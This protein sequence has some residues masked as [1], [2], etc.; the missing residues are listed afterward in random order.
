MSKLNQ[1]QQELRSIDQASFQKL[2]DLYLSQQPRYENL[3]PIGSV[4]GADKVR[5]GIPDSIIHLPEGGFAMVSYTTQ[6]ERLFKKLSD[7][8]ED[9][10]SEA[11][12]HVRAEDVKEVILVHNGAIGQ[13]EEMDLMERGRQREA[14]VR[15]IGLETLANNIYLKYK[16]LAKEF[17]GIEIDTGQILKPDDFV[18]LYNK[19]AF[20]TPLDT[21][22]HFREKELAATVDSLRLSSLVLITGSAG[23]G[24]SRLMLEAASRF[25]REDQQSF[26]VQCIFR[27][28][29]DLFEDLMSY[30]S[31][32]GRY[33]ILVDDANR[34]TNNFDYI[35]QLLH[36]QTDDREIKIMATVRDYARER[37]VER[38]AKYG[39]ISE[40]ELK[41]LEDE[42]ILTLVSDECGIA[43]Q[44]YLR[45]I[46]QL[47]QGNPRLAMMAAKVAVETNTFESILNVT[48]LYEEYF[49]SM[50]EDLAEL[51]ERDAIKVAGIV[52]FYR[53]VDYSNPGQMEDIKRIFG[54]EPSRFWEIVNQLHDLE[55]LD[56]HEGEVA[57]LP[58]QI[59][60][61]YLFYLAVFDLKLISFAMLLH[62]FFPRYRDHF[63]DALNPVINA[64]GARVEEQL[65]PPIQKKWEELQVSGDESALEMLIL[66]F[67]FVDPTR[68]LL[69]IR[70][71]IRA[72]RQEQVDIEALD[73]TKMEE[74]RNQAMPLIALLGHFHQPHFKTALDLLFEAFERAPQSFMSTVLGILI[75]DFGYEPY[76]TSHNL[77]YLT[78]VVDQLWLRSDNGRSLLF[79]KLFL[80]VAGYCLRTEYQFTEAKGRM[81]ISINTLK[82]RADPELCELRRLLLRR[83]LSFFSAEALRPDVLRLL[84]RYCHSG[85]EVSGSEIVQSDSEEILPFVMESLD[86]DNYTHV[87]IVQSY[88]GFLARE[89]VAYDF[90]ICDRFTNAAS[91][92]SDILLIDRHIRT[93]MSWQEAESWQDEKIRDW[94]KRNRP[95]D[96]EHFF[97]QSLTIA[98]EAHK[99]EPWRFRHSMEK[100]F[101][102][103]LETG[104]EVFVSVMALYLDMGNPF[105]IVDLRLVKKLINVVGLGEAYDFIN[106]RRFE[107]KTQWIFQCLLSIPADQ[108]R[109]EHL[110]Q[111]YE[112]YGS[113]PAGEILLTFESLEPFLEFDRHF[114]LRVVELLLARLDR[115]ENQEAMFRLDLMFPLRGLT[116]EKVRLYFGGNF[117]VIKQ[118]YLAGDEV[119][120][121]ADYDGQVFSLILDLD[122]SFLR[123]YMD[124]LIEKALKKNER[125]LSR[126]D[127]KREYDFLWRRDD[128]F[129]RIF[130]LVDQFFEWQQSHGIYLNDFP[131]HI[132][133]VRLNGENPDAVIT[134]RRLR[135]MRHL[136]EKNAEN[137]KFMDFVFPIVTH[138]SSDE[139]RSLIALFLAHNKHVEDF[140]RIHITADSRGYVGSAVPMY[141][142]H[143]DF[144]E[145]L[146]PLVEGIDFLEHRVYIQGRVDGFQRAIEKEK[147]REFMTE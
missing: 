17:L 92:L 60:A 123:E 126:Y 6:R 50:R 127:H 118:A 70:S 111:L 135:V 138:F 24:K 64:L 15:I 136:V 49:R 36:D 55:V 59:L 119:R 72:I 89:G 48:G 53:V 125:W 106:N 76:A 66:A 12:T 129:E 137:T 26:E 142:Q 101:S 73:P 20:S 120:E 63:I 8:L 61:T 147:R 29:P 42:Q 94:L 131:S 115:E 143:V 113:A 84:Y 99:P 75:K 77:Y 14:V 31:K 88:I 78:E 51:G 65:R 110:D 21:A 81:A 71:Q 96:Y 10:F 95:E 13:D 85:Y 83:A 69:E 128:Y 121:H 146:L 90:A 16:P 122:T 33:L 134:D 139:R 22:F 79:S 107:K 28:G 40:V 97:R 3:K 41:A 124:G 39:S 140:K 23:V 9:S 116:A 144:L 87:E 141:R 38:A 7:D 35:L 25:T 98:M 45:R 18:R 102:I 132:F 109:P 46:V 80:G 133:A 32:P 82:L 43:N 54:I 34:L 52:S 58:E 37:V 112:L 11:K 4:I 57:K 56:V 27:R 5:R 44:I 114:I 117:G 93:R 104:P 108:I 62:E 103:L 145:S 74:N 67:W 1:I 19:S 47:S 2:G 105:E 30:F 130:A 100:V 91:V 86:P 68:T